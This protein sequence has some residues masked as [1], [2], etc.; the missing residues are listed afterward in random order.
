MSLFVSF[1]LISF[2]FFNTSSTYTFTVTVPFPDIDCIKLVVVGSTLS[3][4]TVSAPTV[5]FTF[6]SFIFSLVIGFPSASFSPVF[7]TSVVYFPP[8]IDLT[9]TVKVAV[10]VLTILFMRF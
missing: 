4:N 6:T 10:F 7:I 2:V 9:F 3:L 5:I 8:K 1:R